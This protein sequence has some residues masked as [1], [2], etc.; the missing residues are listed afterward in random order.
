MVGTS[1]L[2][3]HPLKTSSRGRGDGEGGGDFY[4]IRIWTR[5][6][7]SNAPLAAALRLT[8]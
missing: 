3:N 7:S 2:T 1:R 4:R 5:Q 6:A 8:I